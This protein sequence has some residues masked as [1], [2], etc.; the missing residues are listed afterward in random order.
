M[1][2]TIEEKRWF[3]RA[4]S[5]FDKLPKPVRDALRNT[6]MNVDV[7]KLKRMA[8]NSNE[9]IHL[10]ESGEAPRSNSRSGP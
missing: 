3:E 8:K 2:F 10:I 9:M 1:A 4:M 7:Y 5:T 6:T